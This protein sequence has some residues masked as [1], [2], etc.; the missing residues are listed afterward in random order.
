LL[1]VGSYVITGASSGLGRE[2][3]PLLALP[4]AATALLGVRNDEPE[5]T[6]A[7]C[8]AAGAVD[9]RAYD[10]DVAEEAQLRKTVAHAQADLGEAVGLFANAAIAR[11]G[12]VHEMDLDR[13]QSVLRTNLTGTFSTCKH[14]LGAT[15][16]AG[17]ARAVVC[18]SSSG[19]FVAFA[20]GSAAAFSAPKGGISSLIRCL[21]IDYAHY[22]LVQTASFLGRHKPP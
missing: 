14:V 5:T 1:Q 10:C 3:A 12:L 20:A 17:N 19:G 21:A 11:G 16:K 7:A 13:W 9:A 8:V 2:T 6:A 15:V 22:E 18:T 4:R